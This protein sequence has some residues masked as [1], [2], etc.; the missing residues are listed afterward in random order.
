MVL[1]SVHSAL[2]LMMTRAKQSAPSSSPLVLVHVAI[3]RGEA[4][5]ICT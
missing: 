2:V 3:D 4:D 5:L 1:F